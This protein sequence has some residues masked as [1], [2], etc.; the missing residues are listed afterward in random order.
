[1]KSLGLKM[2]CYANTDILIELFGFPEGALS[3]LQTRSDQSGVFSRKPSFCHCDA[4]WTLVLGT[5]QSCTLTPEPARC[6]AWIEICIPES[7]L[8]KECLLS[9]TLLHPWIPPPLCRTLPHTVHR[10]HIPVQIPD[11]TNGVWAS[12]FSAGCVKNTSESLK[13]P[14]FVLYTPLL[15]AQAFFYCPFYCAASSPHSCPCLLMPWGNCPLLEPKS[16]LQLCKKPDTG[17]IIGNKERSTAAKLVTLSRSSVMPESD[18]KISTTL[19]CS[20]S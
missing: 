5:G 7:V 17:S 1:M 9:T 19:S 18:P 6:C 10:C 11:G 20:I 4:R 12:W 14:L 2:L 15:R 16:T 3:L 13:L 8:G